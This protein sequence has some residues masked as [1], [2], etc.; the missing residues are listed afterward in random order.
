MLYY[1]EMSYKCEMNRKYEEKLS[2]LFQSDW[3]YISRFLPKEWKTLRLSL[4]IITDFFKDDQS[5]V[6]MF[7]SQSTVLTRASDQWQNHVVL[8]YFFS[9]HEFS[10]TAEENCL[11]EGLGCWKCFL[12]RSHVWNLCLLTY[13]LKNHLSSPSHLCC[14]NFYLPI[15]LF[16]CVI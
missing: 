10:I 4:H 15:I 11:H 16:H 5:Q 13:E 14:L 7:K 1:A 3:T 8:N 12:H 6:L 2:K 9:S